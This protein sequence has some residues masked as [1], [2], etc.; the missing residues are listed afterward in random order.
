MGGG[1]ED[2]SA[3]AHNQLPWK[4]EKQP[5]TIIPTLELYQN[6]HS[7]KFLRD[8]LDC[9]LFVACRHHRDLNCAVGCVETFVQAA[10]RGGELKGCTLSE[11]SVDRG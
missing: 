1:A 2:G 8:G 10:I 3:A 9:M 11:M 7:G 4:D 5:W 6:Q